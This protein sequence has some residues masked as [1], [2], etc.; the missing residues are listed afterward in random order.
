MA[1]GAFVI[2]GAFEVIGALAEEPPEL[3]SVDENIFLILPL[4]QPQSKRLMQDAIN[5]DALNFLFIISSSFL[6]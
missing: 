6:Q 1:A 4:L 5:T 2:T 3:S